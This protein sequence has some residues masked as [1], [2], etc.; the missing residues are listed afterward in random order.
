MFVLKEG[1][2]LMSVFNFASGFW[3][4]RRIL[5]FLELIHGGG[6][7]FA[8]EFHMFLIFV[9]LICILLKE[10]VFVISNVSLTVQLLKISVID[11]I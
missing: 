2:T 5:L 3:I 10:F 7:V 9:I 6:V 11:N 8:F 4:L 1:F